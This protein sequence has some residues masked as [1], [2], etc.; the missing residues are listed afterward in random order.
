MFQIC[1]SLFNDSFFHESASFG[2]ADDP[3]NQIPLN[4]TLVTLKQTQIMI[5]MITRNMI[6]ILI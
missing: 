6:K 4:Q 1:N 5:I 2:Y 3:L